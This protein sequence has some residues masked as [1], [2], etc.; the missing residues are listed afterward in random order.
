MFDTQA[1]LLD[2]Y[3]ATPAILRALLRGVSDEQARARAGAN[4]WSIIE[5]VAHLAD[6]EVTATERVTLMT[7]ED[8]PRLAAYDQEKRARARNYIGLDLAATLERFAHLRAEQIALLSTF[9][10]AA[11]Q[12]GGVHDEAGAITVEALTAHMAAHDAIHLAQI[13][14]LLPA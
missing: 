14:R 9:D 1:E 12:R 6:A 3:R 13:A 7:R 11:W 4:D 10:T 2:T 8:R 5:I